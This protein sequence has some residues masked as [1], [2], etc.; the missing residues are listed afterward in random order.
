MRTHRGVPVTVVALLL[1]PT[2]DAVAQTPSLDELL[3]R[4]ATY[5]ADL[6]P[7]IANVVA[8]ESYEQREN[9]YPANSRIR[10]LK[11]DVLLVRPSDGPDWIV[12][13][14]VG[15]V[16]G[17]Q[18]R[19][20]ADRLVRLFGEPTADAA[21]KISRIAGEG[22]R[23]N[24]PGGSVAATN[25]FLV[26]ALM[27]RFYHSR[28]KFT[29]GREDRGV[30]SG[31]RVLRF[32]ERQT[33][34]PS[35]KGAKQETLPIL[36]P[37]GPVKGNV[38]VE[39]SSGRILKTEG[40][41]GRAPRSATSVTTFAQDDRLGVTMPKEMRTS[42]TNPQT[43]RPVNGVAKYEGFRRFDVRTDASLVQELGR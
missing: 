34:L 36:G 1:F 30:G 5:V 16:N 31:V 27:H 29:M 11:S 14:D 9:S 28:L 39:Q 22:V 42:W 20:E 8:L 32:E 40:R 35:G 4:V 15:E 2:S 19:Y 38:W 13:R 26:F 25:P 7:R 17:K 24:V 41:I 37:L 18:V 10:R 21:E 43:S 33:R 23:F 12:F 6:T 3:T